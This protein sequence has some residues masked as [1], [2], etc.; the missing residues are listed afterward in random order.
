[1][2][3]IAA[4]TPTAR[5]SVS[6]PV[7]GQARTRNDTNTTRTMGPVSTDWPPPA[8]KANAARVS[9]KSVWSSEARSG[10]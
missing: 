10:T 7:S 1:M 9:W 5:A 3:P 2:T 4:T 6:S 8:R